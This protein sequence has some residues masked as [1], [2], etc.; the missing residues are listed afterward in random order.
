MKAGRFR[1]GKK[2]FKLGLKNKLANRYELHLNKIHARRL[3]AMR[4]AQASL[5]MVSGMF[6]VARIQAMRSE[7]LERMQGIA[8]A[9]I[10]TAMS[11]QKIMQP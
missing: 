8:S 5:A 10:N 7:P 4:A 9:I 11:V 3:A 1:K 6:N 2:A